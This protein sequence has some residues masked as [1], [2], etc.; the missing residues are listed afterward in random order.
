MKPAVVYPVL[1]TAF[2]L[3]LTFSPKPQKG[4]HGYLRLGHGLNRK[5]AQFDPLVEKWERSHM[6]E[7]WNENEHNL[8]QYLNSSA[9]DWESNPFSGVIVDEDPE[10]YFSEK[11]QININGRLLVLFPWLDRS[12]KDGFLS[13][14][15]LEA[16]NVWRATNRLNERTL[17]KMLEHDKDRNHAITFDEYL[18]HLS[19]DTSRDITDKT[20]GQA[21]WWKEQ[22]LNA[23]VDGNSRLNFTEFNDFLHP[24]ESN[25][26]KIQLWLVKEK[27]QGMD[28]DK[29]G[30]LNFIEFHD[31]AYDIYKNYI[32]F[33]NDGDDLPSA[34]EK[35]AELDMNMDKYLTVEEL[36]PLTHHLNPG[37]LSYAKYYTKYLIQQA[38]D[39]RDGKLTL[40][41]MLNH[42]HIFYSTV[43][44]DSEFEDDDD[45]HDELR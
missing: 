35:F 8:E 32:E 2:L 3:F 22:F 21:G 39:D 34:E 16:W 9:P 1:A 43:V 42:P 28:N 20:H 45:L 25:N 19:D 38:D 37:E 5:H 30:K 23:D 18:P 27:I 29:D 33:E 14:E 36:R 17:R 7:G 13:L 41:E 31:R 40:D 11:G 44:Q 15:E 24:E 6:E 26:E 4:H 12:P 10:E